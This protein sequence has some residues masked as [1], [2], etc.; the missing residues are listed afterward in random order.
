MG[1]F[2]NRRATESNVENQS[3]NADCKNGGSTKIIAANDDYYG[4]VRLA[5]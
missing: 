5:A 4:D 3:M 1:A 2:W